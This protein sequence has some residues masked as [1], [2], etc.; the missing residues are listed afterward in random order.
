MTAITDLVIVGGGPAGCAAAVMAASVG[1]RSVLI[2]PDALCAKLRHIAAINNVVGGHTSG[3]ELA[4]AV[5]EDI[6]RTELCEVDLGARVTEVRAYDDHV[7]VTMD[8][9]R[10]V[11]GSYAVVATG[12]GPV[13][14]SA[15]SWL[16]VGSHLDLPTLWGAKVS[17]TVA[18][19]L[20]VLGADRPL[21]TFLRAHPTLDATV[22]VAYPPEDDYKVDEVREDARVTLLPVTRLS[23]QAGGA[24]AFTAEWLGRDGHR[25]AGTA[26]AAYLNLGSAPR[27]P[28]GALVPDSTGYCP[29]DR[30]H[31]R[32]L[33]AGDLRS[34]RFQRIMAA[35]GSGSEAALGAYYG[36]RGVGSA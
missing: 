23:V 29:P 25:G 1:M 35:T 27:P 18:G 7:A 11:S 33:T 4:A 5:A 3:T 8:T 22:L 15:A 14:V 10:S 2:E 21:G 24:S 6:A 19:P 16:M 36:L 26:D 12:V 34:S 32:I 17:D 28:Q 31:P 13:P 9:G 20:L 30:Q